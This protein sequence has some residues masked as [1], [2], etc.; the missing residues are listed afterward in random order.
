MKTKRSTKNSYAFLFDKEH[1]HLGYIYGPPCVEALLKAL[2]SVPNDVSTLILR[3]DLLIHMLAY[4]ISGISS[5]SSQS[6]YNSIS[7]SYEGN[8]DRYLTMV[9][10]I[11]EAL[12]EQRSNFGNNDLLLKFGR[13]AVWV[14]TLTSV[15]SEAANLIHDEL[16][17]F[18]P[19]LGFAQIDL[20]SPIQYKLF[21]SDLISDRSFENGTLYFPIDESAESQH[22]VKEYKTERT[23]V[24]I[25][26]SEFSQKWK[27]P[28]QSTKLSKRGVVTLQRYS[29]K[30]KETHRQKI[31]KAMLEYF[32]KNPEIKDVEFT[33][34]L[35]KGVKSFQVE[36]KKL[37]EYLLNLNHPVGKH[38]AKF[39][40]NHLGISRE[41][42]RFL[43]DQIIRG[44]GSAIIF[45]TGLS[46]H[47]FTHRAFLLVKG[48]NSKLAVL[49]TG[50]QIQSNK[51]A[52]LITAFPGD[53]ELSESL[54]ETETIVIDPKLSGDEKWAAIFKTAR[55]HAMNAANNTCPTPMVLDGYDTIWDG[56][57]GFAWVTIPDA[58]TG[59]AKWLRSNDIGFRSQK[60]GQKVYAEIG[61]S[62]SFERAEAYANAFAEVLQAN[63]VPCTVDSRID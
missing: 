57:C 34:T 48:R 6:T 23:P 63:G 16:K 44:M 25:H 15:S 21:I 1:S 55:E 50:W 54:D 19:Y 7:T 27:L 10:D 14:L 22:L 56:V 26:S 35:P 53:S 60:S 59:M 5:S 47:G 3:G 31:A 30:A 58:R 41:D 8:R 4:Q 61:Q 45:K 12:G 51:P 29:S 32:K 20:G 24:G 43:S 62:Q 28:V 49:Q 9:C 11:V 38:K 40:K 33:A 39:F 52:R 13:G 46:E 37:T 42:W 18:D 17:N 2:E 36:E